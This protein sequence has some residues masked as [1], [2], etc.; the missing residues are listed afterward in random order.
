[1]TNDQ[2]L[3]TNQMMHISDILPLC[4]QNME[5]QIAIYKADNSSI[6]RS[7]SSIAHSNSSIATNETAPKKTGP[8]SY[9]WL[10][11]LLFVI[12]LVFAIMPKSFW[13]SVS[14]YL[15]QK[16]TETEPIMDESTTEAPKPTNSPNDATE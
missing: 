8:N 1:M 4:V 7:N 16:R 9:S 13:G 12:V 11:V 14:E 10:G 5:Q 3:R 15:K 6:A 2:H